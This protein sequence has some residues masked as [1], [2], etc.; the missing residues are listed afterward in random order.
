MKRRHD[1]TKIYL[2]S[3]AIMVRWLALSLFLK[4]SVQSKISGLFFLNGGPPFWEPPFKHN[5]FPNNC[6]FICDS[7]IS[8]GTR[9]K[10]E[11]CIFLFSFIFDPFQVTFWGIPGLVTELFPPHLTF[12][13]QNS[14][15]KCFIL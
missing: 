1:L 8:T 6:A 13:Q 2:T 11:L 10:S 3:F 15:F 7:I 5:T 4:V 9:F 12:V 14:K